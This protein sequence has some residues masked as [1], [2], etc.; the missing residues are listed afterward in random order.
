MI[1]AKTIG[2]M[3]GAIFLLVGILGFIPNPI[4]SPNGTFVVN[5]MHNFV[6][7]LTGAAFF[8]GIHFGYPRQTIIGVGLY[9]VGVAVIGFLTKSDM[10]LGLIHINTADRW[11]HLGLAVVILAAGAVSIDDKKSVS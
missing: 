9:Y 4:V 7:L 2:Q 10:M 11:L 1:N 3:F 5:T 8:G 6:H